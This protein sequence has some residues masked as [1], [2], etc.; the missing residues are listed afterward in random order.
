MKVSI[1][2]CVLNNEKY[3]QHSIKSFQNQSYNY[4]E[5][6]ILDGGSTDNTIKIIEKYK[7]DQTIF[8]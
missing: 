3:I 2:T 5:Q 1:I 7:N 6:I 8:I 4:K